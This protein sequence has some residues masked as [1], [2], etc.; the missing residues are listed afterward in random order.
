MNGFFDAGMVTDPIEMDLTNVPLADRNLHFD[1][2]EER[3]HMAAGA[4]LRVAINENF[5]VAAD[6]GRAFDKRDG[7]SGMY[8]G[9]NYLF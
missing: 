3:I 2:N 9:L 4:G 1:L 7:G 5:I 8:I 6:Y